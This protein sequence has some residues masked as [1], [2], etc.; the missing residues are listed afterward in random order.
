MVGEEL[1][2]VLGEVDGDVLGQELGEVL[3]EVL[4]YIL[5]DVLGEVDGD[6]LGQELGEVLGPNCAEALSGVQ[7]KLGE[8]GKQNSF[9]KTRKSM[10]KFICSFKLDDGLTNNLLSS[11]LVVG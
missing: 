1:G 7:Q 6:E 3:G 9:V 10:R 8:S 4:G 2:D 11:R 5:G